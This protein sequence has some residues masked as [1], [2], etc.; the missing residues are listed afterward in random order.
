M[1]ML[2]ERVRHLE[3]ITNLQA[4]VIQENPGLGDPGPPPPPPV[5]VT[6][7][8][9][10]YRGDEYLH[11]GH[12][13]VNIKRLSEPETLPNLNVLIIHLRRYNTMRC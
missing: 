2:K 12:H 6:G 4:K 7:G 11:G 5:D 1:E 9:G 13:Q 8:L 3:R 10:G